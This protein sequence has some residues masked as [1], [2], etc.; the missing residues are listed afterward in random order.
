ME[1]MSGER[2]QER[3]DRRQREMGRRDRWKQGE[4]RG[5]T[6]KLGEVRLSKECRITNLAE[7][8]LSEPKSVVTRSTR[9][10][11]SRKFKPV[12]PARASLTPTDKIRD[13]GGDP[14]GGRPNFIYSPDLP[15]QNA[16]A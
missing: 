3:V 9:R 4:V 10:R 8:S 12:R 2:E 7:V 15:L 16:F 1:D 13:K 5:S 14:V 6:G 11:P